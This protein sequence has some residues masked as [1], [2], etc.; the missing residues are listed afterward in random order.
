ML[1]ETLTR[2]SES[3]KGFA[4]GET[5]TPTED[6]DMSLIKRR[7]KEHRSPDQDAALEQGFAAGKLPEEDRRQNDPIPEQGVGLIASVLMDAGA[8]I[9]SDNAN[10]PPNVG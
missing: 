9:A 7:P 2:F 5:V 3:G 8:Q 6:T 10:Q 4:F 1:T